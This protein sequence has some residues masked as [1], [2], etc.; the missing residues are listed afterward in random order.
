[1]RDALMRAHR[2]LA[3]RDTHGLFER[4][5]NLWGLAVAVPKC[6]EARVQQRIFV[7]L[8]ERDTVHA[9]LFLEVRQLHAFGDVRIAN[10]RLRIAPLRDPGTRT[11]ALMT[12]APS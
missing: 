4:A 7:V 12:R 8:L 11:E 9:L 6:L 2:R 1:M 5:A 3:V 10:D